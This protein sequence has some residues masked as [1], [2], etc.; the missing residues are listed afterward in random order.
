MEWSGAYHNQIRTGDKIIERLKEN[1]P[2]VMLLAQMQSGKTSTYLY[3]ACEMIK[4]GEVNSV[5]IMTGCREVA[6]QSQ[7]ALRLTGQRVQ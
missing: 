6:L 5:I 1:I 7:P 2:Y 4:D 3:V